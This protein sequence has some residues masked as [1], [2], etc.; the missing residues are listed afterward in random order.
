MRRVTW[1]GRAAGP[2]L[3][4]KARRAEWL[5]LLS[6]L[7]ILLALVT[8]RGLVNVPLRADTW[9]I[10]NTLAVSAPAGLASLFL[11]RPSRS[12]ELPAMR[13]HVARACW[14]AL[15]YV[16]LSGC[17]GLG[18]AAWYGWSGAAVGVRNAGILMALTTLAAC[19]LA[20][21]W[22]WA[23]A[24]TF[25]GVSIVYGTSGAQDLPHAWA[26]LQH[27]PD[28]LPAGLLWAGLTGLAYARYA[29]YDL[30]PPSSG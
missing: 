19:H 2:W 11:R 23:P 10:L 3:F 15:S 29:R 9:T 24:L 20:V 28:S 27:T 14:W 25:T 13:L 22:A 26:V 8:P 21:E 4:L 18:L 6:A 30:R 5:P 16:V 1:R 17:A 12:V 7:S